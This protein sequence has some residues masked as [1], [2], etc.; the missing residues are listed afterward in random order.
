MPWK[1]K[2]QAPKGW[3]RSGGLHHEGVVKT[4]MEMGEIPREFAAA[5][6]TENEV[7]LLWRQRYSS[8][9]MRSYGGPKASKLEI[10]LPDKIELNFRPVT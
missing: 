3:Q 4:Q 5:E 8:R 6:M 7:F 10:S 9:K 1:E 2:G